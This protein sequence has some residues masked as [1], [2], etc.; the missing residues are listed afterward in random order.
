MLGCAAIQ[1]INQAVILAEDPA[2]NG[3]EAGALIEPA[4]PVVAGER[5]DQKRLD[6]RIGEAA[7]NRLA[8]HRRAVS[9]AQG[10]LFA[11][12]DIDCTQPGRHLATNS[13]YPPARGR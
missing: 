10:R 6:R 1:T 9:L 12:P 5:V 11:D 3:A 8:Q 4:G 2:L 7:I 13:G